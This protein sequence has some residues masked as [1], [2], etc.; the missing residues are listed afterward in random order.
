MAK[1]L[2]LRGL[3]RVAIIGFLLGLIGAGLWLAG[4]Y[5]LAEYHLHQAR[6][7]LERQRYEPALRELESALRIRPRSAELHL[8]A[9][10]TA[11]Q[12]GKYS[13][14]WDHLHRYRELHQGVSSDLQLEEYLLRAQTGELDEVFPFLTPHLAE[15][16]AQ[17]PLILETLSHAYLFLFRFD[18][19][20]Q[21]LERWLKLQPDNVQAL[22]LRSS[23]YSLVDKIDLAI[24]D[25]RRT[26]ELD[27]ERI[28]SR[29]LLAQTLKE[30]HH[31]EEAAQ[32]YE[33]ALRQEPT[34]WKA[35]LGLASCYVDLREW[36]KAESLMQ[37][38]STEGLDEAEW[39]HLMGR[40]AEGQGR[41]TEAIRYLQ[42][43]IDARPSD[44]VACYHLILCYQRLKDETSASKYQ[45][46]LDRIQKDQGRLILITNKEKNALPSNPDL[47]CELGEICLRL[48]IQRRGVHWLQAALQLN[49]RC[50]RA[51]EQLLHYYE[52]LGPQGEPDAAFHRRM[53]RELTASNP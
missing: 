15:D 8:L 37:G 42:A 44:N 29:L 45:D 16:D 25:L 3:Q 48:G 43:A 6:H 30:S 23:F 20:E 9:G 46:L 21:C 10:R 52:S 32:E 39:S 18:N 4:M 51:H 35:R 34:N 12:A 31:T 40:I 27:P 14:A 53:L 5:G 28:P 41:Y 11:R 7:A 1:F 26:L 49:P 36:S 22:F 13:T 17:T 19:A 38:Y 24:A 50:Q 2:I 33:I 47:C